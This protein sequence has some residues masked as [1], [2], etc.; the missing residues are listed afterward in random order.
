MQV[1]ELH[2][3]GGVCL[4]PPCM[5]PHN[6]TSARLSTFE[7][8]TDGINAQ[9]RGFT[10]SPATGEQRSVASL[11]RTKLCH[12]TREKSKEYVRGRLISLR[13]DLFTNRLVVRSDML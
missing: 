7:M 3:G 12:Y 11:G 13:C 5:R 9:G 6:V 1:R 4:H 10:S 8:L 2:E